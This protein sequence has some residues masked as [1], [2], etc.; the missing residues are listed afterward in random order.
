MITA[1]AILAHAEPWKSKPIYNSLAIAMPCCSESATCDHSVEF[2][3][4]S[5]RRYMN[6]R[7]RCKAQLDVRRKEE[8]AEK[9]SDDMK[10]N[11]KR[12]D[13]MKDD[14]KRGDD[15]KDDKRDD[16][17][18]DRKRDDLAE[19]RWLHQLPVPVC[20][21]CQAN[22]RG[23]GPPRPTTRAIGLMLLKRTHLKNKSLKR[24]N[25]ALTLYLKDLSEEAAATAREWTR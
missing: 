24:V 8:Q 10:V 22:W 2:W 7:I 3:L 9:M 5:I 16:D 6:F 21:S 23:R 20:I 15:M 25:K 1:V 17:M 11:D 4:R 13:N 18:C 19:A 14:D 12:D